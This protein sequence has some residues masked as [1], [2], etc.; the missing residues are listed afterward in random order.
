MNRNQANLNLKAQ[1][2][3]QNRFFS[4]P[5]SSYPLG[6]PLLSNIFITIN[7]LGD[8]NYCFKAG[9]IEDAWFNIDDQGNSNVSLLQLNPTS[10]ELSVDCRLSQ[11][12]MSLSF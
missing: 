8:E 6:K 5:T 9:T 7:N 2:L 10:L 4:L 11:L 3:R 1:S 12:C